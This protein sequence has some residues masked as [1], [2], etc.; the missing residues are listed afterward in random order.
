MQ[1]PSTAIEQPFIFTTRLL[2]SGTVSHIPVHV[3][4]I[5]TKSI[6]LNMTAISCSSVVIGLLNLGKRGVA[7]W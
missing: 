5:G 7:E 4:Y 6:L 1:F 2:V 3:Q